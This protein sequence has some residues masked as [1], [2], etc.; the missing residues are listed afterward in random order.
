MGHP[1]FQ[2]I[3][4]SARNVVSTTLTPEELRAA[5]DDAALLVPRLLLLAPNTKAD[6]WTAMQTGPTALGRAA[7]DLFPP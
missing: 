6:A 2:S 3:G 4:C 5:V 1:T 7:P